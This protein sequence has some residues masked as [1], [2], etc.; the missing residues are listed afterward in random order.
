VCNLPGP[1]QH[2]ARSSDV[3]KLFSLTKTM[4]GLE[5]EELVNFCAENDIAMLSGNIFGA[6]EPT[7]Q[8]RIEW[9]LF[10]LFLARTCGF[11]AKGAGLHVDWV[12]SRGTLL[13]DWMKPN[14]IR[15]AWIPIPQATFDAFN[16]FLEANRHRTLDD[17]EAELKVLQ[18]EDE[19]KPKSKRRSQR[20]AA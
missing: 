3:R 12:Q 6:P 7:D 18:T 2:R 5:G 13:A 17:V 20:V 10:A 11:T 14:P 8:E 1:P 16:A 9:Q 4:E 19:A 15:D